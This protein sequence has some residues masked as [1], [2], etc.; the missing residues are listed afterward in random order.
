MRV[1]RAIRRNFESGVVRPQSAPDM[2]FIGAPYRAVADA[3]EKFGDVTVKKQE[4]ENFT[5][6]AEYTSRLR[7][8]YNRELDNSLNSPEYQDDPDKAKKLPKTISDNIMNSDEFKGH[9]QGIQK[10]VRH[11]LNQWN[12]S[13]GIGS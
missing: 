9:N 4:D 5:K 8:Q 3:L 1:P 10:L 2:S 11:N 12:G 7:V 13:S 6:A